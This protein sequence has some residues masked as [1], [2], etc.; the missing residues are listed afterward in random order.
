MITCALSEL[1]DIKYGNGL[2]LV[3]LKRSP[4]GV[5]FVARTQ[6]NNGVVAK[7]SKPLLENTFNKGLITVAVSGSVMEAFL[8]T[9]EFITGYHVMVLTPKEEMTDEVKLFYCH[10][11]RMN[12]FKYSYGRQAN[13]TLPTIKVPAIE[14]AEEF[15]K[16]F[17]IEQIQRRMISHLDLSGLDVESQNKSES[18]ALVPLSSLFMMRNGT[19]SSGVKRLPYKKNDN[20]IPYVRPSYKQSTSIDAYV[21]RNMFMQDEVY[22]EDTLYV[23][24]DGQGSH[25]YSYVSA[26]DF[27]P[28]SNVT[29]LIPKKPMTLKEKLFYAMCISHNR[30]KFSYGRKPKGDKLGRILVPGGMPKRFDAIR[31]NNLINQFYQGKI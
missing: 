6:K 15:V 16:G 31:K 28:N 4:D 24:T 1:F 10:C 7:V 30:F 29:V 21:N 20:W 2:E 23:S 22:P 19:A 3:S 9:E 11:L 13:I 12:K 8:Q 27:V 17:S 14:E 26:C 25:T 18:E 5:N